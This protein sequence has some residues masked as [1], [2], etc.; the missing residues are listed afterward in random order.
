MKIR[1]VDYEGMTERPC[2]THY[3]RVSDVYVL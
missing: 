1:V 3:H 2:S